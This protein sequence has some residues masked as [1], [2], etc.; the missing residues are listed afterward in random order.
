MVSFYG[1]KYHRTI[2]TITQTLTP[3]CSTPG[4][5]FLSEVFGWLLLAVRYYPIA[6][7]V[8]LVVAGLLWRSKRRVAGCMPPQ[9]AGDNDLGVWEVVGSPR[10]RRA[11]ARYPAGC[12]S[13]SGYAIAVCLADGCMPS[14]AGSGGAGRGAAD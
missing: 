6:G 13:A 3:L 2:A 8:M 12:F 7:L 1:R 4:C 9:A 11:V 14:G 5:I 10:S